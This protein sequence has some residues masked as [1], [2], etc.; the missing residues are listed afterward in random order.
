MGRWAESGGR[1][2][3]KK[4]KVQNS[5]TKGKNWSTLAHKDNVWLE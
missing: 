5:Q 1:K 3:G 2:K 4:Q